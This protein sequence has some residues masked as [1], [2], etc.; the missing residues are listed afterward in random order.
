MDNKILTFCQFLRESSQSLQV[1]VLFHLPSPHSASEDP[2]SAL[3]AQNPSCIIKNLVH[4]SLWF[5]KIKSKRWENQYLENVVE[6]RITRISTVS[7]S[8]QFQQ[9]ECH[10]FFNSQYIRTLS[11]PG[12]EKLNYKQHTWQKNN[13]ILHSI[14]TL[15][16]VWIYIF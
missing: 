8:F 3:S 4:K 15:S 2:L 13:D 9:T 1:G 5:R 12:L 11:S 16:Y 7:H 6:I 14:K 10:L